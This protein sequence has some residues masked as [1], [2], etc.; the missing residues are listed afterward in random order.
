MIV[1]L[2]HEIPQAVV[3]F[4]GD[5][6]TG[7]AVLNIASHVSFCIAFIPE[8]TIY[9]SCIWIGKLE[10]L[11]CSGAAKDASRCDAV[12]DIEVVPRIVAPEGSAPAVL[13]VIVGHREV[14]H[15]A[16]APLQA[17]AGLAVIGVEIGIACLY[18]EISRHL[19]RNLRLNALRACL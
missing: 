14:E 16:A 8:Y 19:V 12:A 1:L 11:H 15:M 4:A 13:A 18:I 10:M 7:E 5:F 6:L 9:F 17:V 3:L 2:D